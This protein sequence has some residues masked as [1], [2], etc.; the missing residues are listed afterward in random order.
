MYWAQGAVNLASIRDGKYVMDSFCVK[1]MKSMHTLQSNWT[2]KLLDDTN[3]EE[4]APT[5]S[6]LMKNQSL[7]NQSHVL[8]VGD[9]VAPESC[10]NNTGLQDAHIL[11]WHRV[12][13]LH[14]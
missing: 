1:A 2:V 11:A 10:M 7:I 9:A 6:L 14:H 4:Y 8:L 5:F 3:V 12:L 13:A